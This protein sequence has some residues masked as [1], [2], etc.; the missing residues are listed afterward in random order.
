MN[1]IDGNDTVILTIAALSYA[2]VWMYDKHSDVTMYMFHKSRA[3]GHVYV[4]LKH[5]VG[6]ITMVYSR[7]IV[8][9]MFL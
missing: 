2:V 9:G 6:M 8:S 7:S 3:K 5:L 1:M 4:A